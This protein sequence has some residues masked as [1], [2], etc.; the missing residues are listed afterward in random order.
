MK[1]KQMTQMGLLLAVA[2]VLGYFEHLIPIAPSLPGVKLGIANT[3]LLYALYMM[4]TKSAVGLMLLK[5]VL[6][7]ALFAGFSGAMYSLAGGTL[8]LIMMILIKRIPGVSIVGVSVV[9]AVFH[10]VGQILIASLT[11]QTKAL[12]IYLPTLLISA[13]ITGVLTG[14]TAKYVLKGLASHPRLG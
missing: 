2:L 10:N 7:G 14:I 11:V 1:L 6:S 9:G 4:N 12:M 8:S 13:V 3:V 5:V